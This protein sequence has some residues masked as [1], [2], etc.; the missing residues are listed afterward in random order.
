MNK[1]AGQRLSITIHYSTY[2]TQFHDTLQR[3]SSH[4]TEIYQKCVQ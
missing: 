1:E 2:T 3:Q 4:Y